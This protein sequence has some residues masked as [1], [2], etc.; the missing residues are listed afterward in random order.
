[1]SAQTE[2]MSCGIQHDIRSLI[3]QV[4]IPDSMSNASI[5]AACHSSL[6][7]I[8]CD[9]TPDRKSRMD[10]VTSSPLFLFTELLNIESDLG[11]SEATELLP[12]LSPG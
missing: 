4:D 5:G 9:S 10:G 2:R 8:Y 11:V 1:M 12:R 3:T 7:A 6:L